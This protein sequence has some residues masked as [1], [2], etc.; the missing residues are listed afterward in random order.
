MAIRKTLSAAEA[1][2]ASGA[3][4]YKYTA[5]RGCSQVVTGTAMRASGTKDS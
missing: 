3:A 1:T 5:M 2:F 4:M